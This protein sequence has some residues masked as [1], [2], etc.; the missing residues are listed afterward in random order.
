MSEA[1]TSEK[2]KKKNGSLK[3]KPLFD[4]TFNHSVKLRSQTPN[5]TSNAGVLLLR[6]A[7]QR[8]A[9]TRDIAGRLVDHR[10]PEWIRYPL[11]ELLRE[12][13]YATALGH[14]RQDDADVLAHDPAFKTAVWDQPGPG[15]AD[16][17]LASQPTSSRFVAMLASDRNREELRQSLALPILRH[18]R[19]GP[20][21]RRVG[22][23]VVDIDGY[24]VETRG[25]QPG[26]VYNGYYG[27]TVYNPL[28][29]YFSANGDFDSRRLGGGFLHAQLRNGNASA[30]EGADSFVDHAIAKAREF[31]KTVSLRL[32]AGFAA[33]AL[34]NHIH[35]ADVRF[36]VRLPDNQA[37]AR[38]A[39]PFLV[40]PQG[41]PLKEG[42]EFAIELTGYKNPEWDHPYRVILVVV[43]KPGKDGCLPLFPHWF[44]IVTNWP[45]ESL[46]P[47]KCL[48]H[49]RQRGTFEDRIGEWNA[50]GVNLSLDSFE[51]NE[52]TLL[53]SMLSFNLLEIVRGEMESARDLRSNPPYATG[54]GWDM[55]RVQRVL[56]KAGGVLARGGRR[57]YFDLAEGLAPL[58]LSFLERIER[59]RKPVGDRRPVPPT[60]F[61]PLPRHAFVSYTPRL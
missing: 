5:V 41:R 36:V 53:L 52:A 9:I 16:E 47:W 30:A 46:P 33:A 55:G 4:F 32:D 57:L 21:D 35:Q 26:A 45:A 58:W 44:C 8:L 11:A 31:A 37:L 29:A 54:F 14:S 48:T 22:L 39:Q 18:Q 10:D 1:K 19:A 59:W 49:Y 34:L 40:R 60:R 56:L 38:L 43:D 51:K 13:L 12:R 6:E 24:P 7:D 15:V 50:L 25:D 27:K 2:R 3:P 23:G 28:A 61:M 20:E 17:R 42:R